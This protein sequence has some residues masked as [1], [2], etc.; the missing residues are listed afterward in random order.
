MHE[1]SHHLAKRTVHI[2]T[3]LPWRKLCKE[4]AW[5]KEDNVLD[6]NP[7]EHHGT[8]VPIFPWRELAMLQL[9]LE[10]ELWKTFHHKQKHVAHT[11][12][13]TFEFR[14][15][16]MSESLR[17]YQKPATRNFLINTFWK[18]VHVRYMYGFIRVETISV[19]YG[20][21]LLI[22]KWGNDEMF[23]HHLEAWNLSLCSIYPPLHQLCLMVLRT[24]LVSLSRCPPLALLNNTVS[25]YKLTLVRIVSKVLTFPELNTF[26]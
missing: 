9:T 24:T 2:T 14:D 25:V 17:L 20:T 6:T 12:C 26:I 8:S 18:W 15:I 11:L 21:P 5:D 19:L 22:L 4:L 10:N 23:Q 13:G 3:M 16:E 7:H 1:S